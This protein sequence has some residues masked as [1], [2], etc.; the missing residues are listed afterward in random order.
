[1]SWLPTGALNG[2][3]DWVANALR[4][5]CAD[6]NSWIGDGDFARDGLRLNG[7]G[8]RGLGQIYARVSVLDVGESAGSKK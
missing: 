8:N 6:P 3:F 2:T 5:T 1:M 4:L 7:E